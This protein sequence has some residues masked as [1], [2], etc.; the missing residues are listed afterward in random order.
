[1]AV[2]P[3]PGH[4]HLCPGFVTATPHPTLTTKSVSIM[5]PEWSF[6]SLSQILLTSAQVLQRFVSFRVNPNVILPQLPLPTSRPPALPFPQ[7]AQRLL[8]HQ[9]CAPADLTLDVLSWPHGSLPCFI[10]ISAWVSEGLSG[11]WKSTHPLPG[12]L[13]LCAAA[14]ATQACVCLGTA[15][16]HW[17]TNLPERQELL[18]LS[19]TAVSPVLSKR[20]INVSPVQ[21]IL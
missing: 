18:S 5:P 2:P 13:V 12:T 19:F 20:L 4:H 7:P 21:R 8:P 16:L 9:G 1:M 14:S 15:C 10:Q 17:D 11:S 3:G 6:G